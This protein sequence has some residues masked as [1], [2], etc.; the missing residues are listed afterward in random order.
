[1]TAYPVIHA[2][3]GRGARITLTYAEALF[4]SDGRKG[5]RDVIEGKEILGYQDEEDLIH[6]DNLVLV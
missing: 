5:N 3:G 4:D 2:S 1:M 6:R